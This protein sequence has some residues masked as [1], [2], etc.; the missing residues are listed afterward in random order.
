LTLLDYSEWPEK[1]EGT[2]LILD[3][4]PIVALARIA[5]RNRENVTIF[6]SKWET[7]EALSYFSFKYKELAAHYGLPVLQVCADPQKT[8]QFAIQTI[9]FPQTMYIFYPKLSTFTQ[10]EFDA[11]TLIA[12]GESKIIRSF[13]DKYDI[14]QY[15]PSIYSH[16]KKRAGFIEGSAE[17]RMIM[18]RYILNLLAW[19]DIPH[20]YI[21]VGQKFILAKKL[22]S[23][24]PPIEIVVKSRLNGTDKYRYVG[25]QNYNNRH[26]FPIVDEKE[27]YWTPYVRFDWRNDNT[28]PEGD[29]AMSETLADNLI[30]VVRTEKL[31]LK[32]F[33]TLNKHFQ[34]FGV[35]LWDICFFITQQG[36]SL[37]GEISQD[38]GR[39]RAIEN[40]ESLD[41][42]VWR[43]GGSSELVLEKWKELSRLTRNYVREFFEKKF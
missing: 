37:F 11:L 41:K 19:E 1:L 39:Y 12:K 10:A 43:A 40:N 21:Y 29:V 22:V 8:E 38:N 20:T 26:G 31:A 6:D 36:N 42:D 27:K 34:N 18:T 4:D 15:I 23:P 7:Q 16:K 32:T 24:P 35:E 33:K 13:N 28:H 14:I 2:H 5:C 3:I 9:L 30:D 25:L 17:E